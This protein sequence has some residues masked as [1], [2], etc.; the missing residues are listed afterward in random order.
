MY[1]SEPKPIIVE[2]KMQEEQD[3]IKQ[4]DKTEKFEENKLSQNFA[5]NPNVPSNY[6]LSSSYY[7][8]YLFYQLQQANKSFLPPPPFEMSNS[9]KNNNEWFSQI[10]SN[11]FSI[12]TQN[13]L[14]G[15]PPF[16]FSLPFAQPPP[17]PH[18]TNADFN[19]L[20]SASSSSSAGFK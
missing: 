10:Y 12:A 13:L 17:P 6:P 3:Q 7:N 19:P 9:T 18:Y 16:G 15:L 8:Q 1:Q 11:Y 2:T 14:S 4:L 20:A 5:T